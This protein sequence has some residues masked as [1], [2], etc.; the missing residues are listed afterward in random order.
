MNT[1]QFLRILRVVAS[2]EN[3]SLRK[4]AR[5]ASTPV[6]SLPWM[7]ALMY[8]GARMPLVVVSIRMARA[9]SVAIR[10]R[11]RMFRAFTVLLGH[12]AVTVTSHM[13]L[14]LA[15]RPICFIDTRLLRASIDLRMG[16]SS[17]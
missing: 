5:L 17:E 1:T 16:N 7:L 13:G 3:A 6:V 11:K 2:F 4:I 14:P 8:T 12:L 9:G 10:L 15:E